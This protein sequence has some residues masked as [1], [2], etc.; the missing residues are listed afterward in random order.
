[1]AVCDKA[2]TPRELSREFRRVKS[3]SE[4]RAMTR[5]AD[6]PLPCIKSGGKRPITRIFAP[7]FAMYLLYEQGCCEYA[8]VVEASRRSVMGAWQ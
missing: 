1:M 6:R 3:E 7:V 8:E 5:K 2:Y 4:I